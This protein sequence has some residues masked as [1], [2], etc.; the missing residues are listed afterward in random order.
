M[1]HN[2]RPRRAQEARQ[3]VFSVNGGVHT[4]WQVLRTEF[5]MFAHVSPLPDYKSPK[6]QLADTGLGMKGKAEDR[7]LPS[8]AEGVLEKPCCFPNSQGPRGTQVQCSPGNGKSPA[9]E[10]PRISPTV[11]PGASTGFP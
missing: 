1:R 11:W 7:D 10:G 2:L 6:L 3:E 5:V 9:G 4:C 8:A